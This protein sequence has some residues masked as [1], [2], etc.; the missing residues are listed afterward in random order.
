[1]ADFVFLEKSIK[2]A[3][4]RIMKYVQKATGIEPTQDEIADALKSYFILNEVGNQIKYQLK[5][6]LEKEDD[7]D[8][9]I[10]PHWTLNLMTGPSQNTLTRAGFFHRSIMEAIQAIREDM[11]KPL[12]PSPAMTSFPRV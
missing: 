5:K 12:E 1:M 11:I 10:K 6:K 2:A 3:I 9:T 4:L 7:K 8:E